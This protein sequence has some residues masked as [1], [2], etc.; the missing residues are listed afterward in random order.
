[1]FTFKLSVK[2]VCF[3]I[4]TGA[5]SFATAY[6]LAA[7]PITTA[8]WVAIAATVGWAMFSALSQDPKPTGYTF[9]RGK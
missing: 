2:T 4:S 6:S 8:G 7:Q 9:F 1:M 3:A 5:A